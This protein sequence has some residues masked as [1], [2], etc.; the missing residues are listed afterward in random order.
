MGEPKEECGSCA[1]W[2]K[3][4]GKVAGG[5]CLMRSEPRRDCPQWA[6]V[7]I[8]KDNGPLRNLWRLVSRK[9]EQ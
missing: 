3:V 1:F 5:T 6:S 9:T 8:L 2:E 7:S 4:F